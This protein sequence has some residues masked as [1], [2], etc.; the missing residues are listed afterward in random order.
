LTTTSPASDFLTREVIIEAKKN[1][2]VLIKP[3][4]KVAVEKQ[5]EGGK[6]YLFKESVPFTIKGDDSGAIQV[7]VNGRILHTPKNSG[8]P[9]SLEVKE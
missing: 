3:R 1:T 4:D 7:M 9:V 6:F 5:L 8:Q 2:F